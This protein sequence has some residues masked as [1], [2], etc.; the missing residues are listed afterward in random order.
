[1]ISGFLQSLLPPQPG[2]E[3][4]GKAPAAPAEG[5]DPLAM[6]ENA[7]FSLNSV[8]RDFKLPGRPMCA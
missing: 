1:M 5:V 7:L 6:V 8:W 4:G 2:N 3:E